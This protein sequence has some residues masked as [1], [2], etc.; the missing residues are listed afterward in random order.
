VGYT[1]GTRD[2]LDRHRKVALSHAFK[3][4]F[5]RPCLNKGCSQISSGGGGPCLTTNIA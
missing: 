5:D 1:A 3:V 2:C 4:I